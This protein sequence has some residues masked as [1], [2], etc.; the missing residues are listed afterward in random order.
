MVRVPSG[1]YEMIVPEPIGPNEGKVVAG[2]AKV[3]PT[4][5]SQNLLWT[6]SV[7]EGSAERTYQSEKRLDFKANS[8]I[9]NRVGAKVP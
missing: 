7:V 9:L 4:L 8:I 5:V 1:P 6:S 3:T 2:A